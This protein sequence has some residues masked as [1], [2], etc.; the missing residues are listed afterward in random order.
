M[1]FRWQ[2]RRSIIKRLYLLVKMNISKFKLDFVLYKNGRVS[3]SK[4]KK[5][6][7]FSST[8]SRSVFSAALHEELL[9]S[10]SGTKAAAVEIERVYQTLIDD[11]SEQRDQ[12]LK[13]LQQARKNMKQ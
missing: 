3:F 12:L 4:R 6:A 9:R 5:N 2:R 11:L 8:K 13:R 10:S 1:K 7:N